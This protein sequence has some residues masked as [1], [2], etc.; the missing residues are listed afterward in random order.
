MKLPGRSY[1]GSCRGS[2]RGS[3]RDFRLST[4]HNIRKRMAIIINTARTPAP[5]SI[6]TISASDR[7]GVSEGVAGEEDG[8]SSVL[9]AVV[10]DVVQELSSLD[11]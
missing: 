11:V 6:T 9:E 4:H 2:Y 5:A 10:Y 8:R 7:A 1:R 3:H